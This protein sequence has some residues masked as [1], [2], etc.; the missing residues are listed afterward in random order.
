MNT[1]VEQLC[2]ELEAPI[3]SQWAAVI[4]YAL[5]VFV[6]LGDW[7]TPASVVVGLGYE[8]PVLFAAFKG[9]K[10]L[11]ISTLVLS[12]LGIAFGWLVDLVQASFQF[13]DERIENRLIS[14]VSLW[15][16][17]S[18]ALALHRRVEHR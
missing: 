9:T 2:R 3:P 4:A 7:F 15:I 8:A 5:V 14:L 1:P 10:R 13:S 12:S 16:V 6:F 18:L 11:T 17:G